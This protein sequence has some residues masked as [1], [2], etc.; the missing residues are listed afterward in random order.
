MTPR[1]PDKPAKDARLRLRIAARRGR[2]PGIRERYDI[3]SAYGVVVDLDDASEV[4]CHNDPR[5][6][7]PD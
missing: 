1:R 4:A 2:K 3:C 5:H 7:F 6:T